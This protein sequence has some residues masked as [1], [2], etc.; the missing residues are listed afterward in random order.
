MTKKK[1][2]ITMGTTHE[3]R[4]HTQGW[5]KMGGNGGRALGRHK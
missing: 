1:S 4:C 2:D 3:E 5:Y